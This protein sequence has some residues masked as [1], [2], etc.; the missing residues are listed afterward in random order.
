[1]KWQELH[2]NDDGGYDTGSGY[3][4]ADNTTTA[5]PPARKGSSIS[6]QEAD[7][8]DEDA[9][10]RSGFTPNLGSGSSTLEQTQ[11][12]QIPHRGSGASSRSASGNRASRNVYEQR[13]EWTVR[14]QQ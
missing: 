8:G 13:Q 12:L 11:R 6:A 1:M 2:P 5:S 4:W 3:G 7:D 10:D 14:P 9:A